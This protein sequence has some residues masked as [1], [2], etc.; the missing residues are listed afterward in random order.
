MTATYH[1]AGY[2]AADAA[3]AVDA[4]RSGHAGLGAHEGI[5]GTE[6]EGED[7]SGELCMDGCIRICWSGRRNSLKHI[8]DAL[9][10]PGRVMMVEEASTDKLK[11]MRSK[12][13]TRNGWRGL[14]TDL[15]GALGVWSSTGWVCERFRNVDRAWHR[16]A[17]QGGV[18]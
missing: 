2:E 15:H 9:R 6:G 1:D 17:V 5:G 18:F 4:A 12:V 16:K 7:N 8:G 13:A 11:D 14:N 10:T 3:E